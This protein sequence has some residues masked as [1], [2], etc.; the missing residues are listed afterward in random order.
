MVVLL[1]L[2]GCLSTS[3]DG[4]YTPLSLGKEKR[5]E[6]GDTVR[7][8]YIMS[9]AGG[10]VLDTSYE[11]VAERLG[12]NLSHA[13][14]PV[15]VKVGEAALIPGVEEALLGMAEGESKEILLTPEKAYGI[16]NESLVK[17]LPRTRVFPRRDEVSM[18]AF[19]TI[20]REPP[21]VN[22][23]YSLS[24][25]NATVTS[26]GN[27]TVS[28]VNE[29]ENATL[30]TGR[31]IVHIRVN[32]SAVAVTIDPEP[33]SMTATVE[34]MGRVVSADE[35]TYTVDLNHPLAGETILFQLV[36]EGIIKPGEAAVNGTITLGRVEFITSLE[37]ARLLASERGKPIF[38]YV[39][40]P[41]CG[42][43]RKFE[44][45]TL[46][47]DAVASLL[48]KRFIAAAL[49]VDA[50]PEEA[51]DLAIYATPTMIFMDSGGR[52]TM[53][54]RGYRDPSS[55]MEELEKALLHERDRQIDDG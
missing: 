49:D 1:L 18:E 45:E 44:A 16:R 28:F 4:G 47:D 33:G 6:P 53:R 27:G 11:E 29:A 50:R 15:T 55:F 32:D 9:T 34:G 14:G 42:W 43:C 39:H 26:I 31:G 5:V 2:A 8:S 3:S 25:W 19:E 35:E 10:E 48:E 12:L 30:E 24:Y 7:L 20:F 46:S 36:V 51:R 37:K 21:A 41:W 17:V 23:S 52:E 13:P 22:R 54:L 40:A 38:L